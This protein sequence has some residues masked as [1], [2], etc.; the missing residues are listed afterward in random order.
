MKEQRL[1]RAF[2]YLLH[3][4]SMRGKNNGCL[5]TSVNNSWVLE[6]P[7]RLLVR[8]IKHY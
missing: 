1:G 2:V 6:K 7:F 4:A 5:E 3:F 8:K